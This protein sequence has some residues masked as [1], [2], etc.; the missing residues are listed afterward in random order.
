MDSAPSTSGLTLVEGGTVALIVIGSIGIGFTVGT[1]VKASC[2]KRS[3]TLEEH[4]QSLK[5]TRE[6]IFPTLSR[7]KNRIL[8][9][10]E[11]ERR[12]QAPAEGQ[13]SQAGTSSQQAPVAEDQV[14]QV[15]P[16]N[17]HAPVI[18]K[19]IAKSVADLDK[20]IDECVFFFLNYSMLSTQPV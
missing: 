3:R 16:P 17:Q 14:P 2:N 6:Q 7:R 9:S 11:A 18:A 20:A 12:R 15:G 13:V 19:D 8:E 10:E 5:R 1:I 4:D